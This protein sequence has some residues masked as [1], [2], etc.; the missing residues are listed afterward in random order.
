MVDQAAADRPLKPAD[1]A[2]LPDDQLLEL[3]MCDLDL[4]IE[5]TELEGRIATVTRELEAR[6]LRFRPRY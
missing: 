4:K 6:G 5:G 2:S 3:R 1:W